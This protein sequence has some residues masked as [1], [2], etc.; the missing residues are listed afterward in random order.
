MPEKTVTVGLSDLA[1]QITVW[2]ES[3]GF[4]TPP[5]ISVEESWTL[6]HADAMLGKLALVH[7]ELAEC[8]AGFKARQLDNVIEE[9]A[10]TAIR[11]LDIAGAGGWP[12][13]QA[14]QRLD[15]PFQ[16][17]A[18]SFAQVIVELHERVTACTDAV[19]SK[20]ADRNA[21]FV[22]ALAWVL[23]GL[24]DAATMMG[25]DLGIAIEEKMAVNANRPTRH[26]KATN[27]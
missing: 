23:M 11:V 9:L 21:H 7:S 26:G 18:S 24:G 25:R 3:K 27:L 19:K 15:L 13:E 17:P 1:C 2:R 14:L 5:S 10:D 20:D 6:S 22:E 12:V 8:S 4:L 16:M